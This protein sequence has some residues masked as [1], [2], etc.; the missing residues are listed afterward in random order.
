VLV[1]RTADVHKVRFTAGAGTSTSSGMNRLDSDAFIPWEEAQRL[2]NAGE[3]MILKDLHG[4]PI[5]EE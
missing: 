1:R 5:T 4:K 2:A 3:V